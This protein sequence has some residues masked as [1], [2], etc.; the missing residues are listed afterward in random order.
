MSAWSFWPPIEAAQI[1]YETLR[2]HAV[3]SCRMPEGLAVARFARRGLAGLI[4]W[5]SAEPIFVAEL[6]DA[7]R[8]AWTPHEDPRVAALAAGYEFLLDAAGQVGSVTG[9][10]L[11]NE[12]LR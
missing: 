2:T 10:L 4:T 8:P 12:A 1:D 7:P 9:S 5:P 3:E 6:L 11:S